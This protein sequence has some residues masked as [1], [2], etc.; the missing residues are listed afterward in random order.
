ME[1]CLCWQFEALAECET[2]HRCFDA[3]NHILPEM[4]NSSHSEAGGTS[5]QRNV[6]ITFAFFGNKR[7]FS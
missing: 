5:L 3:S 4:F 6:P 7:A 1:S 2:E